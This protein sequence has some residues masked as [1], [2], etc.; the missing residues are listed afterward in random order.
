MRSRNTFLLIGAEFTYRK[1]LEDQLRFARKKGFEQ[2][3]A[4]YSHFTLLT[5]ASS[6]LI[7]IGDVC[8]GDLFNDE[9]TPTHLASW[10]RFIVE[11]ANAASNQEKSDELKAQIPVWN[12][13]G[14]FT[15]YPK[16]TRDFAE[17]TFEYGRRMIL[18]PEPAQ[19]DSYPSSRASKSEAVRWAKEALIQTAR[20]KANIYDAVTDPESP[21]FLPLKDLITSY[22]HGDERLQ[23][24]ALATLRGLNIINGLFMYR[25][26]K[27]Y[28]RD[29]SE[30]EFYKTLS[31]AMGKFIN[32][33]SAQSQYIT[34]NDLV[35]I[36]NPDGL[37]PQ[38]VPTYED[39]R[40]SLKSIYSKS[41]PRSS[42]VNYDINPK[43][44]DWINLVEPTSVYMTLMPDKPHTFS[45]SLLWENDKGESLNFF[46]AADTKSGG[47]AWF[48]I[49]SPNDPDMEGL[50][51]NLFVVAGK[52][53]KDVQNQ[54][55]E[56]KL[57]QQ[58][59]LTSSIPSPVTE[60]K[61]D[62]KEIFALLE[63]PERITHEKKLPREV[64]TPIKKALMEPTR[65]YSTPEI[66][67]QLVPEEGKTVDE[68]LENIPDRQDRE[69]IREDWA[70]FNLN[71][72]Y[73]KPLRKK[74][75]DGETVYSLD[76]RSSVP[77]RSR[78]L[79]K[80]RKL[81]Q[82][83]QRVFVVVKEGVGYRK[84]IY[85]KHGL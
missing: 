64:L 39:L 45:I 59:N 2:R 6:L 20:I 31:D 74:D 12:N 60:A 24:A 41:S 82:A 4:P 61:K 58:K 37:I 21:Q 72:G 75:T 40:L 79:A 85:K 13:E 49:D 51:K 73:L 66:K 47:F 7:R 26:A 27:Q 63:Q 15:R 53:L 76:V 14:F 11:G 57:Q 69:D 48:L 56:L 42:R 68:Y 23:L 83:G 30:V 38:E 17:F 46:A 16:L 81:G 9:K 43:N 65:V 78:I 34:V 28:V 71:G 18:T 44:I 70:E 19:L 25:A 50:R 67:L 1:A 52:M 33:T 3:L 5:G 32:E 54:V 22:L 8:M 55:E 77:G 62:D 29:D 84:D 10:Y 80:E 35:T 36:F